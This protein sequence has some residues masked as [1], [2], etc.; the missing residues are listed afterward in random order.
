MDV[1]A[2]GERLCGNPPLIAMIETY[3]SKLTF[4]RK[5]LCVAVLPCK[6]VKKASCISLAKFNRIALSK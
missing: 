3:R 2:P 1:E 4:N 6:I 5:T